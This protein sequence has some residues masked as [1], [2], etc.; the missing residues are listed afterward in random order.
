MTFVAAV[1]DTREIKTALKSG[2]R[3]LTASHSGKV[4]LIDTRCRWTG[5][6]NLDAS[7]T[8]RYPN[9]ARWDYAIGYGRQGQPDGVAYVEVH[10]ANTGQ[11]QTMLNKHTW[12]R[13]WIRTSAPKLELLR[14]VSYHWVPT[15]GIH[16]TQ[17]TPQAR[18]LAAS[19]I[20][21]CRIAE[22]GRRQ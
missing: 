18:R 22:I 19:G 21:V 20:R 3:A 14:P 7:L 8:T 16:I 5:S 9:D 2:L 6:V 17:G 11:V 15:N 1:R 13:S 10:A 4:K 12:L